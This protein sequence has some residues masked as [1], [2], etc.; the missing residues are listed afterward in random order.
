MKIESVTA[1]NRKRAFEVT[2]R[3]G[4][5]LMPYAKLNPQPNSKD[6]V[7]TVFVDP[8]LGRE[9]IT[10]QLD[11]GNEGSIHLDSILELVFGAL[12]D[13]HLCFGIGRPD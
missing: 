6:R 12:F 5:F 11:S 7:V 1:N 10:Y 2:T 8:E 4:V 3:K 9:G 13:A